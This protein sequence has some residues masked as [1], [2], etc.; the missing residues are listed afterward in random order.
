MSVHCSSL[1]LTISSSISCTV[2]VVP[3]VFLSSINMGSTIIAA[4]TDI[5]TKNN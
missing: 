5:T 1:S 2:E 3:S 4:I